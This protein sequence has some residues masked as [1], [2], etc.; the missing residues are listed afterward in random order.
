MTTL[1]KPGLLDKA[2][3][4]GTLAPEDVLAL[5][6]A[7]YAD[8]VIGEP[9]AV[10]LF[11]L[12]RHLIVAPPEWTDFFLEALTVYLVEQVEPHGYV[13]EANAA[14]LEAQ[15]TADG[16]VRSET[17]LELLVRICERARSVPARLSALA[18]SE[19]RR[20]VVEGSG[21]TR[22]GRLEPGRITGPEVALLRRVLHAAG[23]ENGIAVAREEAEMLFAIDDAIGAADHVEGWPD[24]FARAVG[25]YLMGAVLHVP[26]SRDEALAR[27]RWLD[28]PNQ[29]VGAFFGRMVGALGQIGGL[30]GQA[31]EEPVQRKRNRKAAK[32]I[33]AAA[34]VTASEA[35]WVV[36]RI[37]RNG[38]L[39][40][41]EA[42]L[43]DFMR[44]DDAPLPAGLVALVGRLPKAA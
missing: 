43:V 6:R 28:S 41:A 29:G 36:E 2:V 35:D 26:P 44:S 1:D 14:W 23:G 27:Q 40:P 31:D 34:E 22:L 38:S 7:H 18:L 9:E 20:A 21:M 19:V 16:H 25:N 17:E 42:A 37:G 13:D 8:G 12:D 33:E 3:R 5:R 15:V 10:F 39:S 24:L 32:A 4:T 11:D 30:L